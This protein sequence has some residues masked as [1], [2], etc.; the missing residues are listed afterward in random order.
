[1]DV[2]WISYGVLWCGKLPINAEQI[3]I[4]AEDK[5]KFTI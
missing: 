3:G 5:G 4:N 2:L 1:M